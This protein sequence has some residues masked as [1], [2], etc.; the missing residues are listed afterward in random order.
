VPSAKGALM[1]DDYDWG[2]TPEAIK[3]AFKPMEV[4]VSLTVERL[5]VT[6]PLAGGNGGSGEIER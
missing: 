6:I 3:E 5:R 4:E 2:V 1:S